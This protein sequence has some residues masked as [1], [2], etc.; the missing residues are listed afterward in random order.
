V[1]INLC[2]NIPSSEIIP[3]IKFQ[4]P[5]V[6]AVN[7]FIALNYVDPFYGAVSM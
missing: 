6:Q 3:G 2:F 5:C 4:V 7:E 1:S